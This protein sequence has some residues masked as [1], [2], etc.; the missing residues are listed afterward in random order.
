MSKIDLSGIR[1]VHYIKL[2]E[3]GLW[4]RTC[5]AE[6]TLR[7]GYY[8]VAP[9][10]PLNRD[11]EG[12]RQVYL[13]EGKDASTATRFANELLKFY[14]AGDEDL[15]VTFSGGL[16]HW[17]IAEGPVVYLGSDKRSFPDGSSYRRTKT[18]WHS[19]SLDG[20]ALR[21]SELSGRVTKTSGYRGTICDFNTWEQNYILRKIQDQRIEEVTEAMATKS[22]LLSS[23]STLIKLLPWVDFEQL[24]DLIFARTGWQRVGALGGD[25][26]TSDLELIQPMTGE[27]AIVQIKSSTT[28]KELTQYAQEFSR[29]EAN[30]Y[31]YVWHTCKTDLSVDDPKVILMGPKELAQHTLNSGLF[32]WLLTKIG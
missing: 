18:G 19:T 3:G 13:S 27:R 22:A 11:F 24:V 6:G 17:A 5:F 29:M 28:Q 1:H 32:D 10:L 14:T 16:M 31:F 4:E 26:K 20:K 12:I 9:E 25:Q 2:G 7:G 15:W 23:C 30:K 21:M 8:E